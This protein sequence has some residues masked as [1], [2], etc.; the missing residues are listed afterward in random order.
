M[1]QRKVPNVRRKLITPTKKAI[2][3]PSKSKQI[4]LPAHQIC[5]EV[6]KKELIFHN[7]KTALITSSFISITHTNT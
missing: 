5:K 3:A 6:A 2:C 7:E 1:N 4:P